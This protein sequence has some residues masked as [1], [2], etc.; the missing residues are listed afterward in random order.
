M[1]MEKEE[2]VIHRPV[3]VKCHTEMRC[4][5]NGVGVLD[6]SSNEQPYQLWEADKFKCPGCG[7]EVVVGFAQR[8][9]EHWEGPFQQFLNRNIAEHTL[10]AN[11]EK[12][13]GHV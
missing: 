7:F 8:A 12:P 5:K 6:M 10:I 13:V 9:T 3:C 2:T 11:Y 4:E 1:A